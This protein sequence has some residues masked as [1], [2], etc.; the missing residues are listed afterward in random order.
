M[1]RETASKMSMGEGA[2][3]RD[4]ERARES[5][6][7][8]GREIERWREGRRFYFFISYFLIIIILFYILCNLKFFHSGMSANLLC[9]IESPSTSRFHVSKLNAINE[10][11]D[12]LYQNTIFCIEE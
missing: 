5:A 6:R 9:G 2:R 12:S 8:E 4:G 10:K 3:G 1:E 11:I 7:E